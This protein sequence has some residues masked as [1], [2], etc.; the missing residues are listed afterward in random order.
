MSHGGHSHGG[1]GM[2]G[3]EHPTHASTAAMNHHG[4]SSNHGDHSGEMAGHV[5]M[6]HLRTD[7]N[8]LFE[9]WEITSTKV[10][11]GSCI[12]VFFLAV[13]YEGLKIFRMRLMHTHGRYVRESNQGKDVTH[14]W[15][16]RRGCRQNM[17]TCLHLMQTVM[18]VVQ[19]VLGY[20]LML[21]VMT[22]QVYLGVAVIIGAGLGY[23]LFAGLTP[24]NNPRE[25]ES[26]A[27][28]GHCSPAMVVKVTNLDEIR[29][30]LPMENLSFSD[31]A[32][33]NKAFDGENIGDK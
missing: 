9:Q 23:F 14:Y 24:E 7:L 2:H 21:V 18:H 12:A 8:V 22:F 25:T 26:S 27:N 16:T 6:F 13:L 15:E 32:I 33:E 10:L 30:Q 17:C 5:M 28:S 29:G 31:L 11:I 19:V 3:G 4:G 1:D 20:L